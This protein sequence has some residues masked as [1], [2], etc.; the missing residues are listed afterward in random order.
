MQKQLERIDREV[1]GFKGL[2]DMW[3]VTNEVVIIPIFDKYDNAI[4]RLCQEKGRVKFVKE[5]F[6]AAAKLTDNEKHTV[7]L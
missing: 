1:K 6:E 2:I 3:D 7:T 5:V 4:T